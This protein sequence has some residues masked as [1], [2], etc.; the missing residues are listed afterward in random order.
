MDIDLKEKLT[1]LLTKNGIVAEMGVTP[2]K[3]TYILNCSKGDEVTDFWYVETDGGIDTG[4]PNFVKWNI[5]DYI[6]A[7]V[8]NEDYENGR[9]MIGKTEELKGYGTSEGIREDSSFMTMSFTE[10]LDALK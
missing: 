1:E 2:V 8:T 9:Y 4:V 5:A 3:Y 7:C 10:L 6:F